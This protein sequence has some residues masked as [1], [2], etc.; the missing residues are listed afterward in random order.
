MIPYGHQ[1]ISEEDILAVVE[2]L[3]SD[4]ITQ[5][6]LVPKF[7]ANVAE[8]C[9]TAYGVA[10]NSGTSALH[11]ACLA[12]GVGSGDEVWTSPI[13][14]VASA[15]CALL[16]GA[17]VDFVD[18]DS[19]T[20][21][22]C[23]T[24]L[25]TKLANAARGGR[26]PKA[27]IP[28]HF[29][30]EP[31]DMARIKELGDRYGFSII[32]D[33]SHAIGGSYR[34][35][36]IGRCAFSDITVFSFHPVKVITTGEGG[37]AVTHRQDLAERM[38]LLRNHG[39]T[40]DSARMTQVPDG[41]WYYQ[42]IDL[43]FNYRMTDLQAALGISQ[44][45]R[46]ESFVARRHELAQR[47]D[48]EL[49]GLPLEPLKRNT[50]SSSALHLYVVRLHLQHIART[51]R[52][53]FESLRSAGIGVQV[54]YIP[55]HLQPYYRAMSFSEGDFPEAEAFYREAI[56]LPIFPRLTDRQQDHVVSSLQE[57]LA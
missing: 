39:I 47:Y 22:M 7:E 28:V 8:R 6:P 50:N 9:G 48:T 37:M 4:L 40:H 16:C 19:P 24:A 18:I 26:C 45:G 10:V 20:G 1:S 53:V 35:E 42:Q 52:E 55:V 43:G 31:C 34:G 3:R 13:T 21:N 5:G 46:I 29:S 14:F 49:A 25:E 51:H 15:S 56:S 33:A 11:I 23:A 57:V 27:V 32:E 41:P 17:R 30:G 36:P 44:L 38:R 54:H 12:L 2:V